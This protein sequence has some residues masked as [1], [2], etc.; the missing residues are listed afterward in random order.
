MN[1]LTGVK[2]ILLLP[3][4]YAEYLE[5]MADPDHERH[6]ELMGWRG[7]FDPE[8]FDLGAVNKALRKVFR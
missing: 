8:A 2:P 6:E 1:Q 7:E 4:P 5:A 3:R